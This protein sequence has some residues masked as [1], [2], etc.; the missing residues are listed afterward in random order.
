MHRTI[1]PLLL[2]LLA[3]L[4][5]TACE[6]SD[7]R[8]VQQ[9]GDADTDADGDTDSDTDVDS[10]SDSDVRPLRAR[11][12]LGNG[13]Y[14]GI[15]GARLGAVHAGSPVLGIGAHYAEVFD[16]LGN[17]VQTGRLY[18]FPA[19]SLPSDLTE[20]TLDL[21]HPNMQ[22]FSGFGYRI[23]SPCDLDGDGSLDFPVG[24][25]L[26]SWG[27]NSSCGRAVVFWGDASGSWD[28]TRS[29]LHGLSTSLREN[30]DS[31]G[32]SLTCIEANGDEFPDLLAGGQNA[33]PDNTG[34]VAVFHGSDSG[35]PE[36][37]STT[38]VPPL[39]E[40]RQYFGASSFAA[41]V[42]GDG[43]ADLVVG[44][45]GLV[46]GQTAGGPHTGGVLIYAGGSDWSGGPTYALFPPD[47]DEVQFGGDMILAD[48]GSARLLVV[49]AGDYKPDGAATPTGA[50]FVYRVGDIS[51][52]KREPVQVLLP[53]GLET[54]T[55]FP[56]GFDYLPDYFGQN[57]GALVAGL[58]YAYVA[59]K[60]SGK[61]AVFR[62]AASG[63]RFEDAPLTLAG[64]E[65]NDNDA[66]GSMVR[67]LGDLDGDGLDDFVVGMPSH[68]EG[69][70]QT[71]GVVIFY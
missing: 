62:L 66:F 45:W 1:S 14:F 70:M 13:G 59:S 37:E 16:Q 31:I 48:T 27:G 3:A 20:A 17:P 9:D 19:D 63:D 18:L 52:A 40:N 71:G 44:G 68:V 34:L 24:A 28:R 64:P 41:D 61:A 69:D 53:A 57:H 50:L 67:A 51:F 33:G 30:S 12:V 29:S 46:K 8:Y 26:D 25:H 47:D 42:D 5:L 11:V 2:A 58:R 6:S 7:K 32:Q 10:D 55:G 22:M 23:G 43:V 4:A 36:T 15:S 38:L 54:D 35:L 49:A 56:S 65:P 60:G 39:A 21:W